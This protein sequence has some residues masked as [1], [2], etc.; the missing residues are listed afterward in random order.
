[1]Y[2]QFNAANLGKKTENQSL[3]RFILEK[4]DEVIKIPNN[5]IDIQIVFLYTAKQNSVF[6]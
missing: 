4:T 6:N 2:F 3:L 1:M 5:F